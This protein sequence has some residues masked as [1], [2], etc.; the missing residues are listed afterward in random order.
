MGPVT[1][2]EEL[3]L[4]HTPECSQEFRPLARGKPHVSDAD[5]KKKE[6]KSSKR[7]LLLV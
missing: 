1:K 7:F 4:N 6:I 3:F 5:R 2:K